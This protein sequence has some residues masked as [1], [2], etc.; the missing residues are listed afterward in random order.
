V[1]AVCAVC[2]A[3]RDRRAR[4]RLLRLRISLADRALCAAL[5]VVPPRVAVSLAD[6]RRRSHCDNALHAVS[7][8]CPLQL[9]EPSRVSRVARARRVGPTIFANAVFFFLLLSSRSVARAP[10]PSVRPSPACPPAALSSVGRSVGRCRSRV[11]PAIPFQTCKQ[12]SASACCSFGETVQVA[13]WLK[14]QQTDKFNIGR[15]V[16]V[17][18]TLPWPG[19]AAL[20]KSCARSLELF[21]CGAQCAP[22]SYIF[23]DASDQ[24]FW[25]CPEFCEQVFQDCIDVTQQ[26]FVN[27][28]T[29]CEQQSVASG[30]NVRVRDFLCYGAASTDASAG[31]SYEHMSLL[32]LLLFFVCCVA[33]LFEREEKEKET[34]YMFVVL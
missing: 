25:V 11:Q 15:P 16:R 32:L 29:F 23:V 33:F 4:R 34:T 27:S 1:C 12:F 18:R 13:S 9:S 28:Q 21:G 31:L 7:E 8:T 14:Q 10:S 30:Y 6:A 26:R 22:D 24:S 5:A 17:Q 2:V 20:V 3:L 19:P